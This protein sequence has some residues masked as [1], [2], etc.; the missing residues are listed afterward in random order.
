MTSIVQRQIDALVKDIERHDHTG[1]YRQI[2]YVAAIGATGGGERH[3]GYPTTTPG[4]GSVGAG[5]GG[6][7]TME[8]AD[9][10]GLP[11][12][13]PTTATEAAAFA[14]L[15]GA[16]SQDPIRHLS[17]QLRHHLE[18]IANAYAAIEADLR[19]FDNLRS[20]ADLTEPEQCYVAAVICKLPFDP[21]WEHRLRTTDFAGYLPHPWDEP[22]KVCRWTYDFVRARRRLPTPDE[23]RQHLERGTVRILTKETTR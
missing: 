10:H 20:T 18:R 23:M 3:D 6:G 2:A 13:V 11:D 14:R 22:R 17:R 21:T 15:E 7:R 9:E 5:K 16:P 12:R 8:I 4:N 19:R 1:L